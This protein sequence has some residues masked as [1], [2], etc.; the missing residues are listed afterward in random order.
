MTYDELVTAV[1]NYTENNVPNVDMNT[2]IR[3]AEQRIYNTVQFP[4]LRKNVTGLTSIN[5]KYL[6]CPTDFLEAYSMAV[7]DAAGSYEY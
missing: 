1:T 2:F 5:N 7:I 6:S 4:S 3:Q